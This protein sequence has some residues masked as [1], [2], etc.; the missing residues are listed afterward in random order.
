MLLQKI[1]R[2]RSRVTVTIPFPP[3]PAENFPYSMRPRLVILR[4]ADPSGSAIANALNG[5]AASFKW[6]GDPANPIQPIGLRGRTSSPAIARPVE[7]D[8]WR[9]ACPV[10]WRL[11][12]VILLARPPAGRARRVIPAFYPIAIALKQGDAD[13]PRWSACAPCVPS[14]RCWSKPVRGVL[15]TSEVAPQIRPGGS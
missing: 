3:Y 7:P 5:V 6:A 11:A 10:R 9:R 4:R 14:G 2:Q 8:A 12:G 13:T 1:A 15:R